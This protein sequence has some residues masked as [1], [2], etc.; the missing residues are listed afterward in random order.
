M[1]ITL[2][3]QDVHGPLETFF[4]S[5][6]D[7]YTHALKFMTGLNADILCEGHF[8]IIRG[9]EAVRNFILSYLSG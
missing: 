9:R 4:F 3:G 6:R 2:F 5:N 1:E 7:D 8:G